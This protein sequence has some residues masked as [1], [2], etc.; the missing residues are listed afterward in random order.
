MSFEA[1][2]HADVVFH[3]RSSA[4]FTV[5][6]ISDHIFSTPSHAAILSGVAETTAADIPGSGPLTTLAVKN[7]GTEPIRVAGAFDVEPGRMAVLPT[8]QTVTVETTTGTSTYTAIWI[9]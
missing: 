7:T 1:R 8:S 5:G 2:V 4:T 9:G 3:E 6:A